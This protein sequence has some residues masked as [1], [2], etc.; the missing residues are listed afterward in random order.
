MDK[1][2]QVAETQRQLRSLVLQLEDDAGLNEVKIYLEALQDKERLQQVL[3]DALNGVSKENLQRVQALA[4]SGNVPYKFES[5]A[6]LVYGRAFADLV[7]KRARL[8]IAQQALTKV[9]R[10]LKCGC[11]ALPVVGPYGGL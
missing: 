9:E 11:I 8:D 3:M 6:K 1:V 2:E 4:G 5:I 7:L 10:N